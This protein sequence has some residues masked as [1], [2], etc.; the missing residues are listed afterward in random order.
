MMILEFGAKDVSNIVLTSNILELN[1]KVIE[2]K[3]RH[4]WLKKKNSWLA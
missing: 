1:K 2:I 4:F 3:E